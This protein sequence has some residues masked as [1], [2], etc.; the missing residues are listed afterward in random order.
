MNVTMESLI[1]LFMGEGLNQ[2]K[3]LAEALQLL[4]PPVV[5][6]IPYIPGLH[7]MPQPRSSPDAGYTCQPL[8][9]GSSL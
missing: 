2:S 9:Q 6:Q 8:C 3:V 4:G 1:K 5:H 7:I